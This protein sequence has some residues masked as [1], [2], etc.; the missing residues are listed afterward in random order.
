MNEDGSSVVRDAH[1]SPIR[2][3]A[4]PPPRARAP[5]VMPRTFLLPL[6]RGAV[7]SPIFP[8]SCVGCGGPKETESNLVIS[9][10]V[11]RG[12]RQQEVSLKLQVPHC[13]RCARTTKAVFLAGCIPFIA[14]FLLTGVA[15]F[16]VTAYWSLWFGLDES[17]DDASLVLG[18]AAGLL[19]GLA[20]G[21]VCEAVARFILVPFYGRALLH[22]PMLATQVFN[23]SDHVAGLTCKL[24]ADAS[25]LQLKFADEEIAREFAA[26]N[27]ECERQGD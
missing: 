13:A 3:H 24:D 17:D 4:A 16:L 2:A 19:V 11:M 21:F 8:A 9:R 14:G 23:S 22:A 12:Q 6:A 1:V 7:C 26:L 20:G 15:A 5:N 25:R 18:A 27:P 10:L